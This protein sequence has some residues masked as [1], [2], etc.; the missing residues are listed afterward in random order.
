MLKI[1]FQIEGGDVLKVNAT[2]GTSL[3]FLAQQAGIAIDAPCGGNGTCGKCKVLVKTGNVAFESSKHINEQERQEG[4]RLACQSK[5][6]EDASIFV[7]ASVLAYQNRIRI[8]DI[9]GE[10]EKK[11]FDA[12]RL[13]L[14]TDGL[15]GDHGI[16]VV[17]V[18]LTQPS[19][20]DAQADK[21]RLI[22][23]L[24]S[25]VNL[26]EA[27][28][29]ITLSAI[30]KMPQQLRDGNFRVVC[31]LRH[32]NESNA[33]ILNVFSKEAFKKTK[34]PI[35]G[36]A[37]DIGTT[38]IS[39]LLVD[40]LTGNPISGASCGNSQIRYGADVINRIIES[41]KK[42][43]IEKLHKAVV[44]ESISLLIRRLC[45]ETNVSQNDILRVSVAA[46]T[47]M[48]AL[49]LGVQAE[50]IRLE[51]YIPPFFS[52]SVLNAQELA[53]PLNPGA[54]VILAPSV[55]SYVGGDITSGVFSSNLYKKEA[56]TLFIDL[57]TNGEIVLGNSEFMMACACSAGP[58]FEGGEISCGMRAA[59]GAIE[60]CCIDESTMKLKT[61]VIGGDNQKIA[62]LCGSG[63]IDIISELF[64][65]G[66][67]NAKGKFVKEGELIIKDEYGV[68]G[69][70]IASASE[71]E[72]GNTLKLT[73][74][75][76]DNFVRAKGAIF[77]AI[78][79]M[80]N[81]MGV[82]Q[83]SIEEVIVAGGI[84]S[85]INIEHAILIGMFPNISLDKYSYIGNSS[86]TGAYAMLMSKKV[87]EKIKE[88]G[89][90]ITYLELSSDPTYM[91]EFVASCF[92]P[93]TDAELFKR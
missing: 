40:L 73:E 12:L 4:W 13:S 67:I 92:L 52:G 89:S 37:I 38:T 53:L 32:D 5:I 19:L 62:G 68:S 87:A 3:L 1:N 31:I 2:E 14:E 34:Y 10:R 74:I 75:D 18:E 25:I 21:E 35:T 49:F 50:Y 9:N 91:D 7:P 88:I 45:V 54:E 23:A 57:G 33:T 43:G 30:K 69:Y 20:E 41:S 46:N 16:E 70:I 15:T 90:M 85:G 64:R 72:T 79:T 42:G 84:G 76:I 28:L 6:T 55:G 36:L 82:T 44:D 29:H 60:A 65:T 48:T 93:H 47:T 63:L 8:T 39:I 56:L 58:A 86:L 83:D 26:P 11:A 24:S 51:P 78:R 59:N 27:N 66:I 22:A 17:E 77:S 71:S 61:K 81:N 80:L